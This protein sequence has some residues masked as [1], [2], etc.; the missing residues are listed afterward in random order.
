MYLDSTEKQ[1][2]EMI[3]SKK[4]NDY[5]NYNIHQLIEI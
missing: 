3:K 1:L 4:N 2:K 5:R